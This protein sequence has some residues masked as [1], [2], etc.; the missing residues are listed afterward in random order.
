MP[1]RWRTSE[2]NL[3]RDTAGNKLGKPPRFLFKAAL[4]KYG[5][6]LDP[7]GSNV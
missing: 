7:E 6:G 2:G 1:K 4:Q 5:P 3:I